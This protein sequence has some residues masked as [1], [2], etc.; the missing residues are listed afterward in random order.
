MQKRLFNQIDESECTFEC[1]FAVYFE[2]ERNFLIHF[3]MSCRGVRRATVIELFR[4][5]IEGEIDTQRSAD[6]G[7]FATMSP[8][9][10]YVSH[11]LLILLLI[12]G[13]PF[14]VAVSASLRI[15]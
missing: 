11:C 1:E 15:A 4:V 8:S 13:V 12:F 7:D 3:F 2:L 14:A 9:R 5:G 10:L 6:Y